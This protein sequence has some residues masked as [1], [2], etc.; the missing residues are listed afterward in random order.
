MFLQPLTMVGAVTKNPH[1]SLKEEIRSVTTASLSADREMYLS[2]KIYLFIYL[3]EPQPGHVLPFVMITSA[4]ALTSTG[5]LRK[6]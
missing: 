1:T 4:H 2:F 6:P 3:F 5:T